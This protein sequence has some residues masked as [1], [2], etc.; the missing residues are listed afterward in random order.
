M[1]PSLP[2]YLKISI[3]HIVTCSSFQKSALSIRIWWIAKKQKKNTLTPQVVMTGSLK[4]LQHNW[5]HSFTEGCSAKTWGSCKEVAHIFNPRTRSWRKQC[6]RGGRRTVSSSSSCKE[7]VERRDM[8]D[9]EW[10]ERTEMAE[11]DLRGV[12]MGG[13][14]S[15]WGWMHRSQSVIESLSK[16]FCCFNFTETLKGCLFV[17][18]LPFHRRHHGGSRSECWRTR[19]FFCVSCRWWTLLLET[20]AENT[21]ETFRF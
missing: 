18:I 14:G 13:W 7:N 6:I 2:A 8:F 12:P 4:T 11:S 19:G 20:I 3:G 1:A 15:H 17:A 5:Q 10:R 9:S 16:H 21:A